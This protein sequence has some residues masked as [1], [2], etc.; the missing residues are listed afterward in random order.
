MGIIVKNY[1]L[2]FSVF[3][4]GACV[5]IVEVVAVRI[6][7]PHYGNTMFTVSSVISI[8]LAALSFG[9]YAGGKLADQYPYL[10]WFF[11]IILAS[12]LVL[13]LFHFFGAIFL[14]VLS[15]KLSTTIGPL[16]SSLILFFVPAL[17]LGTL[18]PYAVK[19]QSVHSPEQGIGSVS[20]K[21]FFWSTFGSISGSILAG[22]FLIPR[23]GVDNII[24]AIAGVL[25]L[26][27]LI[28]LVFLKISKKKIFQSILLFF[29]LLFFASLASNLEYA[30][31]VYSEHGIYGK[32]VVYDGVS[33]NRPARFFLHDKSNSGAIFLDSKDPTD[34]V[35]KYA[36]YYSVYEIFKPEVKSVLI[37]GGGVYSIA[38]AYLEELPGAIIDVSEIEPSLFRISQSYFGLKENPRLNN[39][40]QDGRRFLKNSKNKY[41]LIFGDAYHS[42]Y[43]IPSHLAT[44]EFF[45]LAKEKLNKE[46]I[47]IA[48]VIG[49]L[50]I[51]KDSFLLSEIRTFQSAF[52][53]SYFFA[54]DSVNKVGLQNI[55]FIGYNSDKIIDFEDKKIIGSKNPAIRSL[56]DKRVDLD[57][58]SF[59]NHPIL[60]D[61]FSPT[62]YMAAKAIKSNSK[63]R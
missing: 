2:P 61:N 14:P 4:T 1:L 42:L 33:G 56:S 32:I 59:S 21:I 51:Q 18:S 7:S 23:F 30:G 50:S 46:G 55:I 17:L 20:G 36:K 13:L 10:K 22:F 45:K 28:P 31:V 44:V 41:D 26:A 39:Y 58:F 47:F 49:D 6:L 11:G 37:I 43:S 3:I 48:N 19:L 16:F 63:K 9:Y 12:G 29:T 53:N 52:P 38:K 35:H 25:F 15:V 54:V 8:I 34:M 27:G 40:T 24:I 60:T 62:D 5:L 57:F